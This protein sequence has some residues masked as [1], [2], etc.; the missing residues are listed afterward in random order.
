MRTVV[1]VLLVAL[2][3]LGSVPQVYAQVPQDSHA[4]SQAALD[5]ALQQRTADTSADRDAVSRVLDRAEVKAVAGRMGVDLRQAKSA[6]ATLDS[7]QLAQVSAQA[8]QVDQALAGGA[9]TVTISTTAIII[10][11]LVLILLIIA[12]K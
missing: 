7:A 5:A 10:G 11:L 1:T 6:I 9:S 8:R 3:F 12:L 2:M 4:A